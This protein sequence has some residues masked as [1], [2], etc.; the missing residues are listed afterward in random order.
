MVSDGDNGSVTILRML[1]TPVN[2][3]KVDKETFHILSRELKRVKWLDPSTMDLVFGKYPDLGVARGEI[4]TGLCAAV[5]SILAKHNAIAFSKAN[6][7]ETISSERF[8]S[9]ASSIADLF[10]SRF[11]PIHPLST[12][13]FDATVHGIR[14]KIESDVEDRIAQE[15]LMKMIEVVQHTL[16]TNVYMPDRYA[17]SLRLDPAIMVTIDKNHK[18]MPF[19][20]IFVHGRRFNAFHVRFR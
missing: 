2:Q 15:L 14:G 5:H 17:L 20:V 8:I 1:V 10:L 16:K 3:V 11:N 6:I 4:I 12:K 9:H 19:G 7:L 13:E 18:E